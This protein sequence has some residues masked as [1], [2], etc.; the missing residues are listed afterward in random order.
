MRPVGSSSF[1]YQSNAIPRELIPGSESR[2]PW[3]KAYRDKLRDMPPDGQQLHDERKLLNQALQ[4][5][6]NDPWPTKP[7]S[8]IKDRINW[9]LGALRQEYE[10]RHMQWEPLPARH[11]AKSK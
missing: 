10:R 6:E 9:Q 1:S 3:K 11:A 2:V 5:F 7:P 4:A 8:V